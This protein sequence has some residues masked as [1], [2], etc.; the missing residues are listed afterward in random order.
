M[1][2]DKS[3][4]LHTIYVVLICVTVIAFYLI[5]L[6]IYGVTVVDPVMPVVTALALAAVAW[7]VSGGIWR[8]VM[9][10]KPIWMKAIAHA[11]AAT[12]MFLCIIFA[13]NYLGRNPDTKQ[14][15]VEV[16]GRYKKKHYHTQR[17][18]R[19]YVKRGAPY[20]VYYIKLKFTNGVEKELS[21]TRSQYKK[22]PHQGDTIRMTISTGLLNMPIID[23]HEL[24]LGKP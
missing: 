16:A 22:A 15:C 6:I 12:G 24:P 7:P 19:R 23:R 2:F 18:N 3:A 9:P 14:E 1:K 13:L 17:V 21:L 10:G 11:I 8:A 4:I 5:A 20:D